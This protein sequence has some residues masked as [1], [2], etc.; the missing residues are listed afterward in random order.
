[1]LAV[2]WGFSTKPHQAKSRKMFPTTTMPWLHLM[3]WTPL[4]D[5]NRGASAALQAGRR[6]TAPRIGSSRPTG[7]THGG[8]MHEAR[9]TRAR[10]LCCHLVQ[11][12]STQKDGSSF[13]SWYPW[14]VLTGN[15]NQFE[16]P[17]KEDR[18]HWDF[19]S[20]SRVFGSLGSPFPCAWECHL[21]V[22]LQFQ[23]LPIIKGSSR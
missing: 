18:P 13:V 4:L 6:A 14:L 17:L 11:E 19:P 7:K 1:M 8:S 9:A 16:G 21:H 20:S 15:Q 5:A 22:C 23:S 2:K 12:S 10:K 3:G